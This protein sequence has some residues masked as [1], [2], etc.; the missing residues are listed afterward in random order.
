[1]ASFWNKT[2]RPR[3]RGAR[4]SARPLRR[5]RFEALEDRQM[6]SGPMITNIF[7]DNRGQIVLTAGQ[8][9]NRNTV[10][11]S[12]VSVTTAGA[13][14]LFGTSDDV[15]QTIAVTVDSSSTQITIQA[16]LTPDTRYRV[17]LDSSIIVDLL[18]RRLDG[19]FNGA[20]RATGDGTEGGDLVFFTKPSVQPIARFDTVVGFMDVELFQQT[21]A[22]SVANF[23]R[24]ANSLRYDNSIIHR[25][26][27]TP[28]PFIIQGGGFQANAGF[29]GIRADAPIVNEPGVSNTRGTLAYAKFPNDPNSATSQWFFNVG[30]NSGN[31]D[32][33]NGGFTV[34]GRIVDDAGL[35][36]MD[37]ING[38]MTINSSAVNPSLGELPVVRP[39]ANPASVQPADTVVVR[40]VAIGMDL[41]ATPPGQLPGNAFTFA[42][43]TGAVVTLFDLAGLGIPDPN[44]MIAVSFDGNKVKSIVLKD[45]MPAHGFGI[46]IGGARS[47]GSIV[48]KR[49]DAG[50]ISF[51][52]SN[53]P[54]GSISI[55][56]SIGGANLNGFVVAGQQ[57][58]EDIDGDGL[59]SDLTAILLPQGSAPMVSVSGNVSGDIMAPGGVRGLR[60]DGSASGIDIMVG[61]NPSAAPR[62]R[63]SFSFGRVANSTISSEM[64]LTSFTTAEWLGTGGVENRLSAPR[65]DMLKITGD[66]RRGIAGDFQANLTITGDSQLRPA[67]GRALITGRVNSSVMNVTGAVGPFSA[68]GG[69][70][71]S[72]LDITGDLA[73]FVAGDVSSFDLTVGGSLGSVKTAEWFGG[74]LVAD[75]VRS[76][77]TTGDR[78]TGSRGDLAIDMRINGSAAGPASINVISARGDITNVDWMIQGSARSIVAKGR[79]SAATIN[80]QGDLPK[81][82]GG[83]VTATN[84]VTTGAI[85]KVVVTSWD[86]GQINPSGRIISL[87]ARGDRRAGDNGDFHAD[88][89]ADTIGSIRIAGDLSTSLVRTL[90]DPRRV[91]Q[92][93]GRMTVGGVIEQTQIRART[94]IGS[95]RAAGM[96]NSL[97]Y[98]AVFLSVNQ[99]PDNGSQVDQPRHIGSIMLRP[100]AD[101][102]FSFSNSYIV[103][104]ALDRADLGRIG[105][106]NYGTPFGVAARSFGSLQ[107]Q[108]D[109]ASVRYRSATDVTPPPFEDFQVRFNY[110]APSTTA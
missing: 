72:S 36:V 22:I 52:V 41:E 33:Q 38:L 51:I 21:K 18:G 102:L 86:G 108:T 87:V 37:R 98:C 12:S 6:L 96:S 19:E 4:A 45:G 3:A 29:D 42:S 105:G 30:D 11:A 101:A 35:Q 100:P 77:V 14:A 32:S 55:R 106:T 79:I 16:N 97:V 71:A 31:L 5:V 44:A 61:N 10:N 34:F 7:A 109:A 54:V 104:G 23:L 93:I 74:V 50:D 63:L 76:V 8:T 95:I 62:D 107:Y 84:L 99:F 80:L 65:I 13:D 92:G 75:S 82:S 17:R 83:A 59:K 26:V 70:I 1:M 2:R 57:L 53:A 60:I 47:V 28:T 39:V 46:A 25:S 49:R 78:R 88:I 27:N 9:L 91:N 110:A 67:L 64:A 20:G 73:T 89:I 81:F 43:G 58:P 90:G 103:T 69:V 48:D 24:Y 66:K 56:G 85:N 68:R 40:R 15:Q 94:D